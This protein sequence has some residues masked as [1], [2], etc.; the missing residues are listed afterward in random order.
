ML[1]LNYRN[2]RQLSPRGL[3]SYGCKFRFKRLTRYWLPVADFDE[4]ARNYAAPI[5]TVVLPKEKIAELAATLEQPVQQL[6]EQSRGLL[7]SLISLSF[8]D[9]ADPVQ[10]IK[11]AMAGKEQVDHPL[12]QYCLHSSLRLWADRDRNIRSALDLEKVFPDLAETVDSLDTFNATPLAAQAK[13]RF[14]QDLAQQKPIPWMVLDQVVDRLDKNNEADRKELIAIIELQMKMVPDSRQAILLAD[15]Y[16]LSKD[17]T[18]S[19]AMLKRASGLNPLDA[20]LKLRLSMNL[21]RIDDYERAEAVMKTIDRSKVRFE[22]D[23][24]FCRAVI[25]EW[26]GETGKALDLYAD[27][28]TMRRYN[29]DYFF[30]YGR[31]LL[32]QSRNDDAGIALNWAVKIDSGDQ[33]SAVV[34]KLLGRNP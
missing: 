17:T 32:S 12:S 20:E 28:I 24:T 8:I 16:E 4:P 3:G 5:L 7:S 14:K 1:L 6:I 23:Y 11:W 34:D 31:L 33:M 29:P 27:A 10:A 2:Y 26:Q 18:S 21:I 30:R 22:A 13:E 15:L 9:Q 19:L 25:A